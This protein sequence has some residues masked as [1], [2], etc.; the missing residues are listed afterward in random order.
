M[1]DIDDGAGAGV[2][3][4][5]TIKSYLAWRSDLQPSMALRGSEMLMLA[6][7]GSAAL[8]INQPSRYTGRWAHGNTRHK[9]TDRHHNKLQ[10]YIPSQQPSS[11]T[12]RWRGKT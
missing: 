5:A 3:S 9:L 7:I 6:G 11:R 10:L 8:P 2:S 4:Q 12:L 1:T